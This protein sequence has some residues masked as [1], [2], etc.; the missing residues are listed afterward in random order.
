MS[1]SN[2]IATRAELLGCG[3]VRAVG[4]GEGTQLH[5]G[6]LDRDIEVLVGGRL[7][8][9][10]GAGDDSRDH[11]GRGGHFAHHDTVTRALLLL[12]TVGQSLARAEV[13]EVG[14]VRL[15]FGLAGLG[16]RGSILR[17]TGLDGVRA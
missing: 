3:V 12:Q 11:V 2:D 17:R 8:T 14:S 1:V 15:R 13:D 4:V 10:D 5:V 9:S 7:L 16:T 6:D